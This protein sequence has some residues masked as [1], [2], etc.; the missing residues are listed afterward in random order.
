MVYSSGLQKLEYGSRCPQCGLNMVNLS[1]SRFQEG[2]NMA[3]LS[4]G[5][6]IWRS[7]KGA[8]EYG[9]PLKELGVDIRQV[10]SLSSQEGLICE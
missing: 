4:K 7:F 2:W 3:V 8:L 1:Y 5:V 9:S 10:Y 6:G